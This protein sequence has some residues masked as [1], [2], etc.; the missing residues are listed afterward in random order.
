MKQRGRKSEGAISLQGLVSPQTV[1]RPDAPYDLT[2]EQTEVWSR[3]VDAMPADWF[4]PE[5]WCELAN[6][7]RHAV[8]S[9]R[10][11]QLIRQAES[12]DSFNLD[13]YDNLLKM[14]ER[15]SRA[16][17]ALA[18][19]LRIALSATTSKN[20]GRGDVV[21]GRKNPWDK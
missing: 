6:Y 1:E 15:E 13:E 17:T 16:M 8:A 12:A 3:V 19:S 5:T 2:D 11:A 10:I 4:G 7:C 20:K 9:R 18:R 21:S 14:Q